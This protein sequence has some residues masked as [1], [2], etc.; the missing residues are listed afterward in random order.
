M[1]AS[2]GEAAL[3]GAA[4]GARKRDFTG[5]TDLEWT[6]GIEVLSELRDPG[7]KELGHLVW[8]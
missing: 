7:G 1:A 5:V 6:E 4:R 3:E 2:N 8:T